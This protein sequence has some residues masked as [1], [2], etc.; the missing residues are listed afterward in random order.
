MPTKTVIEYVWGE[1]LRDGKKVCTPK[2]KL[3]VNEFTPDE[4]LEPVSRILVSHE[5]TPMTGMTVEDGIYALRY[6]LDGKR[7]EHTVRVNGGR[8]MAAPRQK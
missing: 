5:L 2:L 7:Q 1:L 4:S 6:A 3:T 8:L